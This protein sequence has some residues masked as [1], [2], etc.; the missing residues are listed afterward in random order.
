MYTPGEQRTQCLQQAL[1]STTLIPVLRQ[2]TGPFL[3]YT[4]ACA[5][6]VSLQLRITPVTHIIFPDLLDK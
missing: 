3:N 5:E 1:F 4:Y 6:T 2:A